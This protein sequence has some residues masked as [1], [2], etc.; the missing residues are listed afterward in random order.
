MA[1]VGLVITGPTASGK[2]ALSIAVAERLGGE[3]I[4]MD[5]RQVVCGMNIGTAKP[6][7]EE[8]RGIPH[9]GLDVVGPAER[10]SAG[11]FARDARR[12]IEA[13]RARDRVPVLVGGTGFFLRALSEPL[14]AEPPL[15]PVRRERLRQYLATLSAVELDHWLL[16]LDPDAG[17]RLR[18]QGGRQR[19]LRVL[20][21]V[22]LTG[23]T[24]DWWH[25]NARPLAPALDLFV[26][27]LE[28]PRRELYR[29]IDDRVHAMVRAGLVEEV[30]GLLAA[31]LS[32]RDPAF[33]ATG[34]PEIAA[35]LE[36]RCTLADA[37][38]AIQRATRR[39]ARRQITW[40]R[41][42]LPAHAVRID[43]AQAPEQLAARIVDHWRR[44]EE[45]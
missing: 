35:Y 33:S 28:L 15:D 31:G 38:E 14:F 21:M 39:Y 4:S 34:Y 25:H 26:F 27:V 9:H 37:V 16:R 17:A 30:Q 45:T 42:Q 43:A 32:V 22:L 11:A 29:R 24:L 36:G 10:Y 12:W 13:I 6:S 19:R 7:S 8:R 23:R 41:H 18:R 1:E 40:F 20:E 44:T 2:T 5:S 3:I